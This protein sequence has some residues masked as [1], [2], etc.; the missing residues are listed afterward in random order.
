MF[1]VFTEQGND[2][3]RTVPVQEIPYFLP[4]VMLVQGDFKT[5]AKTQ[6]E[7]IGWKKSYMLDKLHLLCAMCIQARPLIHFQWLVKDIKVKALAEHIKIA[8][9]W[10]Q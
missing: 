7:I 8:N 2:F 1:L 5:K 10:K 4:Y 9:A 6:T 3:S